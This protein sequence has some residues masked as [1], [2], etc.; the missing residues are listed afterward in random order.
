[1]KLLDVRIARRER[2]GTTFAGLVVCADG[3]FA[4][5][6]VGRS[7]VYLLRRERREIVRLTEDHTHPD[8]TLTQAIGATRTLA[9]GHRVA[10]WDAGDIALLCTD[11][12]R[13]D[14]DD[15]ARLL[16]EADDLGDTALRVVL[17]RAAAPPLGA[18]AP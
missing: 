7:R 17:V 18:G 3:T 1:M 10:G 8:G 13:V 5:A 4:V 6:H 9:P 2:I 11:G 14:A 15:L 12:V 16:L